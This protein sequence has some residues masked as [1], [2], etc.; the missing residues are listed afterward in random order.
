MHTAPKHLSDDAAQW[1]CDVVTEFELEQHHIR[2]LT[3]ACEAW[4]R[5]RYAGRILNDEGL[6]YL[7][8]YGSP[9]PRPEVAIQRDSTIAFARLV[10][11]LDL[12][13]T[14]SAEAPR[15]P[16]IISNRAKYHAT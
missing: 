5:T 13:V 9:R 16:A 7:D 8:R 10:R 12:D 2:L 15:P 14:G 6:T 11:E 1:W 3:L 4:D